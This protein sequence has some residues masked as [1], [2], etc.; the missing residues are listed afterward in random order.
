MNKKELAAHLIGKGDSRV[1]I[2]RIWKYQYSWYSARDELGLNTCGATLISMIRLFFWHWLQPLLYGVV[3]F[4]YWNLLVDAQKILGLIVGGREALYWFMTVMALYRN[5]SYLLV[6]LKATWNG[7]TRSATSFTT[8]GPWF[9]VTLYVL[10]PEKYVAISLVKRNRCEE[11]V[12]GILIGA[13]LPLLDLAGM[14]AFCWAFAVHN[15]FVPMIIGYSVTMIAALF[16]LGWGLCGCFCGKSKRCKVHNSYWLKASG[17]LFL[18]HIK[19]CIIY[20]ISFIPHIA[21][22]P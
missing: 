9:Q 7:K 11:L 6:D 21:Y 20:Q 19:R 5:P 10:A 3:L 18:Y 2:W 14:V 12:G 22:T 8:F 15:V 16:F 4:A 13:F 17:R 1:T